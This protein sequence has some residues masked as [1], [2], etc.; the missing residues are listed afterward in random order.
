METFALSAIRLP[1]VY[2]PRANCRG[3]PTS[4]FLSPFSG[5]S[6]ADSDAALGGWLAKNLKI[7]GPSVNNSY[8]PPARSFPI[9]VGFLAPHQSNLRLLPHKAATSCLHCFLRQR[10]PTKNARIFSR[11]FIRASAHQHVASSVLLRCSEALAHLLQPPQPRRCSSS[12]L[13]T[14][15]SFRD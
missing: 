10:N 15:S 5:L 9:S 11:F 8:L 6:I 1:R 3:G 12:N 2:L 14:L 7:A 4:L 13:S